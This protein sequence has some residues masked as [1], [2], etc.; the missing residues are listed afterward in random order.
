[1]LVAVLQGEPSAEAFRKKLLK[2]ESKVQT[3]IF[4]N[5]CSKHFKTMSSLHLPRFI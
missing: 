1:M 2:K 5:V 3:D 4:F